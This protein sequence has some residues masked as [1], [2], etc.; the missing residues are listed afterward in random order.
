MN[1]NDD[2]LGAPH[3]VSGA[4]GSTWAPE[5]VPQLTIDV[6]RKG[7][8]IFII[9]TVAGVGPGDLDISIDN[10]VLYIRGVRRKPYNDKECDVLLSECFFGEFSREITINEKIVIEGITARI[11]DGILTIVIPI[12]KVLSRKISVETGTA[13]SQ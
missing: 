4:A 1:L 5:E 13:A 6:Y 10:N 7:D 9:S 3:N 8:F 2:A 11:K 12:Q